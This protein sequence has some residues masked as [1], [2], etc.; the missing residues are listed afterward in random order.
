M[1]GGI[2]QTTFQYLLSCCTFNPILWLGCE[3]FN[4]NGQHHQI[5]IKYKNT[6]TQKTSKHS[7][8]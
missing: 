3:P 8:L 2:N 1:E 7:I 5:I 4:A 6:R